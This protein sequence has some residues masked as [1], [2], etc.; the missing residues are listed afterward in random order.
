MIP[1]EVLHKLSSTSRPQTLP[2]VVP[3]FEMLHCVWSYTETG[4]CCMVAALLATFSGGFLLCHDQ[5]PCDMAT[6]EFDSR[7]IT[8]AHLCAQSRQCV[9]SQVWSLVTDGMEHLVAR[10][11]LSRWFS[12]RAAGETALL[13]LLLSLGRA[14]GILCACGLGIAAGAMAILPCASRKLEVVGPWPPRWHRPVYHCV[15]CA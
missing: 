8:D 13:S 12:C 14:P 5:V 2:A 3:V 4:Q 7:T 15:S 11:W 6:S 9:Q 1:L 10:A